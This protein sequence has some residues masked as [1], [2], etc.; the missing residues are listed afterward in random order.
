M[1]IRRIVLLILIVLS[2]FV[3]ISCEDKTVTDSY[4]TYYRYVDGV[5]QSDI[6]LELNIDKKTWKGN[7]ETYGTYHIYNGQYTFYA[8]DHD[9]NKIIYNGIFNNDVLTIFT[10]LDEKYTYVKDGATLPDNYDSLNSFQYTLTPENAVIK[11]IGE[12]IRFWKF[13]QN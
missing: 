1:K 2:A 5:K 11:N 6:W 8:I 7:D 3:L 4:E 13:L 9:E 10:Y 12:T